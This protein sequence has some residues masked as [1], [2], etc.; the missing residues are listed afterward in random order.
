MIWTYS[1]EAYTRATIERLSSDVM[2]ALRA[3]VAHCR[4]PNAGGYTPSDFSAK[5]LNQRQLDK[6]MAKI[7]KTKS[8]TAP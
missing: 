1:A 3:L 8:E 7:K 2:T 5:K 4:A 6:L